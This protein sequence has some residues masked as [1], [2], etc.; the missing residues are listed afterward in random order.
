MIR[1]PKTRAQLAG[2]SDGTVAAIVAPDRTASDAFIKRPELTEADRREYSD[3]F[4]AA[5]AAARR[6]VRQ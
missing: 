2:D 1:R 3:A 4:Y 6:T 5:H